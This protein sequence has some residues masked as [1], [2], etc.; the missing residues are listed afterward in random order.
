M[1]KRLR[2]SL[3]LLAVCVGML[4]LLS[5]CQTARVL[6]TPENSGQEGANGGAIFGT[7]L[8][9]PGQVP[10]EHV[11]AVLAGTNEFAF[12]LAKELLAGAGEGNVLYSPY[13]AWL[14]LTALANEAASE[15]REALLE[16]LGV[17]GLSQEDL[18]AA[19]AASLYTMMDIEHDAGK[20]S[21]SN[22]A[23][24]SHGMT[25]EGEFIQRFGGYY[26]GAIFLLDFA[27]PASVTTVNDWI[28][29]KTEGI[30]SELVQEFSPETVMTLANAIYYGSKWIYPFA[31]EDTHEG[32]FFAPTGEMAVD[33]MLREDEIISYYE[34]DVLQAAC[35]PMGTGDLTILLPKE[36]DANQLLL[37]MDWQTFQGEILSGLTHHA[38]KILLPKFKIDSGGFSLSQALAGLGLP[39]YGNAP[40]AVSG[41]LETREDVFLD[42]VLQRTVIDVNEEGVTAAGATVMDMGMG[43]PE[44][45]EPIAMICD[46]PFVFVLT[47]RCGGENVILFLGVVN[48]PTEG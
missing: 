8:Q 3:L 6:P 32:S 46:R 43:G 28:A 18:A 35:L 33:F 5:A 13:S 11:Q 14:P 23:F 30:I 10:Q 26:G 40:V 34:N 20:L 25:L 15:N 48:D 37:D 2:T 17:S 24:V 1:K 9:N 42:E 45:T 47:A 7:A 31:P 27:D 38:G 41:V 36:G 29:E 4:V 16:V 21:V 19:V 12:V 44:P 22:A 39:F